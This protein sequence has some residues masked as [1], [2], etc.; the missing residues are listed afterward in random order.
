MGGGTLINLVKI[1]QQG[2]MCVPKFS[3]TFNSA[4]LQNIGSLE[5][6]HGTM[7]V[8]LLSLQEIP[9]LV[10]MISPVRRIMAGV[11]DLDLRT[12]RPTGSQNR[13]D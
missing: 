7:V 10:S 11:Q 5:K 12:W 9:G 3:R 4:C 13:K 2:L 1:L 8:H 6:G